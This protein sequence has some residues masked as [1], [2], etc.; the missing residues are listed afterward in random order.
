ML[1][2]GSSVVYYNQNKHSDVATANKD[3]CSIKLNESL[4]NQL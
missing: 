1:H 3:G 2:L 4:S